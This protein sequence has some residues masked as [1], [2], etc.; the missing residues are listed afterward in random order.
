MVHVK[1]SNKTQI[2]D[3]NKGSDDHKTRYGLCIGPSLV[4][5]DMVMDGCACVFEDL[6]LYGTEKCNLQ[7]PQTAVDDKD[8]ANGDESEGTA[9]FKSCESEEKT[10]RA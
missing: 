7:K 4:F 5:A 8:E 10:D 6:E 9:G 2:Q 3:H 1:K